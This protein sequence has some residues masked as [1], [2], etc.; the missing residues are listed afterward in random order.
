MTPCWERKGASVKTGVRTLMDI[1]YCSYSIRSS[2]P[3]TNA[4]DASSGDAVPGPRETARVTSWVDHV[5]LVAGGQPGFVS[6]GKESDHSLS[7][8]TIPTVS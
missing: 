2:A 6:N 4:S 8:S 3:P 7:D 5:G 1:P